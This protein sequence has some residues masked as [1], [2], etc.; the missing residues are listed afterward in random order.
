M[1]GARV[2]H[3]GHST[4]GAAFSARCAPLGYGAADELPGDEPRRRPPKA[5]SELEGLARPQARAH[6]EA[7]ED[8][9]TAAAHCDAS[10]CGLQHG[11]TSKLKGRQS[12]EGNLQARVG[13]R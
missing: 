6:K 4:M 11:L 1:L 12:T 7:E 5:T 3:A 8:G 13:Q 2:V 9:G 10:R